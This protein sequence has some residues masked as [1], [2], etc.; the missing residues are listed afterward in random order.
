MKQAE[1]WL[2]LCEMA[3]RVKPKSDAIQ[4]VRGRH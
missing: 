1:Q 3:V 4:D 2:G